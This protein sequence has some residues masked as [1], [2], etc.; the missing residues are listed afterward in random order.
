[1]RATGCTGIATRPVTE[2]EVSRT[3]SLVTVA[4]RRHA[5]ALDVMTRLARTY[6]WPGG[7]A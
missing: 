6:P 2:P 3:I 5:P 7:A 4:G 1:M